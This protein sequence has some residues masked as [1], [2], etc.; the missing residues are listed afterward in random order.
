MQTAGVWEL[1]PLIPQLDAD[2]VT[3]KIQLLI[4]TRASPTAM[5][6]SIGDSLFHPFSFP[7][8]VYRIRK[9]DSSLL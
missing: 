7:L 2:R 1:C 8:L 6:T 3:S 9:H 5:Q 4:R